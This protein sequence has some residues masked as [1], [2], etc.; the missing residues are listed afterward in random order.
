MRTHGDPTPDECY[1]KFRNAPN[2]VY[3]LIR[4]YRE[5]TVTGNIQRSGHAMSKVDVVFFPYSEKTLKEIVV[6]KVTTSRTG[7][8]IVLQGTVQEVRLDLS[9]IVI[10]RLADWLGSRTCYCSTRRSNALKNCPSI[11]LLFIITDSQ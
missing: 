5:T 4:M 3:H 6:D 2:S 7:G 9:Y 8:L 10:G 11:I 1:G